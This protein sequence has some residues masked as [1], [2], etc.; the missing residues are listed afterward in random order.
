MMQRPLRRR[1]DAPAEQPLRMPPP[2]WLIFLCWAGGLVL[3]H[4]LWTGDLF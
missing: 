3:L 1:I 4:A 2:W